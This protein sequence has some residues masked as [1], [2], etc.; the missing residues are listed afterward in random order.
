MMMFWWL[1]LWSPGC[2][3]SVCWCVVQSWLGDWGTQRRPRHSV[4]AHHAGQGCHWGSCHQVTTVIIWSLL[5]RT[6]TLM[7]L[8]LQRI[9]HLLHLYYSRVVW[10]PLLQASH[11]SSFPSPGWTSL[12]ITL[13][14]SMITWC[15]VPPVWQ[16][17]PPLTEARPGSGTR[18]G[19]GLKK[20]MDNIVS[21][22]SG[23]AKNLKKYFQNECLNWLLR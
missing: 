2:D 4:R 15:L 20:R 7:S 16:P 6:I 9:S 5:M 22:T 18:G 3:L 11:L 14:L 8:V 10:L 17:P 1:R 23:F 19:P 21:N 13:S 12:S